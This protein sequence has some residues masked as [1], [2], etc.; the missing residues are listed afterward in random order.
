MAHLCLKN[1]WLIEGDD[2]SEHAQVN[3]LISDPAYFPVVLYPGPESVDV[4][5][6]PASDRL[7]IFPDGKIP[8]ILVID[9]TWNTARRTM[10]R[11]RNLSRLPQIRF[12]P[13]KPSRIRVRHQPEKHCLTTLEAIHE[14]ACLLSPGTEAGNYDPLLDVLDYM[15]GLQLQFTHPGKRR[16]EGPRNSRLRRPEN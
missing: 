6:M 5:T 16:D 10:T 11:S 4:S 8:L 14:V 1:S 7:K 3:A 13:E 12:T 2:F 9:G 15:V